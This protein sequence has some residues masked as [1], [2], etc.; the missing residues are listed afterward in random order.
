MSSCYSFVTSLATAVAVAIVALPGVAQTTAGAAV[1]IDAPKLTR[2]FAA[3]VHPRL[4][5]PEGEQLRYLELAR[6]MLQEHGISLDEPQYILVIDRAASVQAALLY[7]M[8]NGQ[9]SQLIGATPVSTG[10]PAGFDHF[11]TP[12]GIHRHTVDN[13]DYRAVG[14]RNSHGIRGYGVRGMRVFDLGWKI[15]TR[16][17]GKGG[18]STIRLQMHATD[19]ALLEPL[20]GTRQ[21]KGCIRIPASLNQLLDEHGVLDAEYQAAR[22]AGMRIVPA[23]PV[24]DVTG[25]GRYIIVLDTG[26]PERPDWALPSH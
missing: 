24:G 4:Q 25:A 15:A 8:E 6:S 17:W 23:M 16:G 1:S 22:N 21:S 20:L 14:T 18:V 10:R 12:T 5:L 11:L 2:L 13:P 3:E 26:T 9:P 7:W 19:P